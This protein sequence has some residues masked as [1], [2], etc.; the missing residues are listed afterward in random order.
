MIDITNRII[1]EIDSA[2]NT[3]FLT[4]SASQL[5]LQRSTGLNFLTTIEPTYDTNSQPGDND[6][7]HFPGEKYT[8]VNVVA[9]FEKAKPKPPIAP[10][11]GLTLALPSALP[12]RLPPRS[13]RLLPEAITKTILDYRKTL[14]EKTILGKKFKV[15]FDADCDLIILS[16]DHQIRCVGYAHFQ[17][18]GKNKSLKLFDITKSVSFIWEFNKPIKG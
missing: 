9:E 18:F 15:D 2:E 5:S 10:N 16:D 7:I 17:F 1:D 12:A 8:G 13:G 6:P 4:L 14:Y 11:L 3:L